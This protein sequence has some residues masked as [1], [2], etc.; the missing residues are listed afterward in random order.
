MNVIAATQSGL[1]A[2]I[3]QLQRQKDELTIIYHTAIA[4]GEKLHEVKTL[5]LNIKDI[6]KRLNDLL[7]VC[8]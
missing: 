2:V 7:R 6:D 5:Y 3:A 4:K 1:S 8:F